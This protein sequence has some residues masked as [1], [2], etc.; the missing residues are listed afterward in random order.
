MKIQITTGVGE[1]P[2][3][4]AAFD[5]ALL[6][7]GVANYNLLCLSSVIP[8]ASI[9]ERATYITPADKY[10]HRLYIVMA[11]EQAAV[12]APVLD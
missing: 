2:A 12:P 8:P 1:G 4:L 7:A 6:S 10:G 3:P 9:I 5:T 11:Q